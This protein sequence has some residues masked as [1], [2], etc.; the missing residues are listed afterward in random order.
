[1]KDIL[2]G[3]DRHVASRGARIFINKNTM[4][5]RSDGHDEAGLLLIVA[6]H[7]AS[8]LHQMDDASD[9]VGEELPIVGQL[10]HAIAILRST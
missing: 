8:D 4:Q 10:D 3:R 5:S 2:S 9:D 7:G 1:M 6:T